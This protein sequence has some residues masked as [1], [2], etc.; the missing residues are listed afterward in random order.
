MSKP[1]IIMAVSALAVSVVLFSCQQPEKQTSTIEEKIDSL[2]SKM[3]LEEKVGMIHANSSFTTAGVEHLGIPEWVMSDGPHGVRKEHGRDWV[4]D[5]DA[6]DS[7]T[8]LPVGVALAAT[9]NRDLGYQYGEVLGSEANARGKDVILG[10][11]VCIQRTPLNGRN[12]EYLTEDPYL[13]GQMAIS[14]V[15]GVQSQ[16]VAPC[17]KHYAANNEEVDRSWV[18]VQMSERALREIYLPGFEAAITEGGAYTIMGAYNRFRGQFC[19]HNEYLINKV[20]KGDWGFDGAVISDWGAVHSTMDAI[21]Y[22]TDV[23]MGTDLGMLPNPNYGKFFMGDTVIQLVKAGTVDEK[24]ID[25]K[26]RRILRIM[27]RT[28]LIGGKERAKGAFN[29][30]EHQAVARKV[31]EESLVL[32]KNE[33]LL[34][35]KKEIQSIAIVGANASWKH[36]GGGGSSQVNAKY[37]ITPLAGIKAK[38]GDGVKVT[39]AQGYTIGRESKADAKLIAEA[40]KAASAAEYVVYVGGWIHGYSDA[41]NDN[42]Y[43]AEAVDKPDLFMPFGQDELLKA[44]LKANPKTVVVLMGGG[45]VEMGAWEPSAK[46]ILQAWYPGMEGGNAIA[47]VLFGDLSPSGKLPMTFPKTLSESPAHVLGEYPGTDGKV[48]YKDDIYVGY[49]YF[50]TK[51]VAPLYPF[52]FGLSYTTFD[53]S[54]AA[55]EKTGERKA[56]VKVTI[57]NTGSVAGSEVVQLYVHDNDASVERPE[58]ELKAFE[59]VYLQPGESKEITFSLAERAFQFYDETKSGWVLES[60]EFTLLIGT[61]SRDIKQEATVAF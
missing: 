2:L 23:E 33:N 20:L 57:K 27:Y 40:V 16:D 48:V 11:G 46:A 1:R 56:V 9:W 32:L 22:G 24:V 3:T 43:D 55:V 49:R 35:L 41:W 13:N 8:Y 38:L 54:P 17:V 21:L 29:T 51:K 34:P 45:P 44:I 59:K 37:E 58:K 18:D 19:T 50:D 31:A 42:A 26:V 36:A 12:F 25:D 53:I 47:S 30:P 15:K 6:D 7:A 61:S 4:V 5:N 52:G 39:Y 28:N 60:G 14:Y 10:P